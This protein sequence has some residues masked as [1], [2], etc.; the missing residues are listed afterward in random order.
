MGGGAGRTCF[1]HGCGY[2]TFLFPGRI[3]LLVLVLVLRSKLTCY[4][5]APRGLGKEAC[6]GRSGCR[7]AQGFQLSIGHLMLPWLPFPAP[8]PGQ[9]SQGHDQAGVSHSISQP[10]VGWCGQQWGQCCAS[11]H[12]S[13]GGSASTQLSAQSQAGSRAASA[14]CCCPDGSC[15]TSGLPT[16]LTFGSFPPLHHFPP[17]SPSQEETS[18]PGKAF[19]CSWRNS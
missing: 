8:Q 12:H 6:A 10:L 7:V 2:Q 13:P 1:L 14:L 18:I 9:R 4:H 5:C 16:A 17:S 3:F 15:G 11:S 19:G